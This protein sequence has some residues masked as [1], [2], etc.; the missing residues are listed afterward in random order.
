MDKFGK[1]NAIHMTNTICDIKN[2]TLFERSEKTLY[3][4]LMYKNKLKRR[5]YNVYTKRKEVYLFS[6][7]GK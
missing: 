3:V 5:K 2:Q 4:I 6:Y 7:S 1:V